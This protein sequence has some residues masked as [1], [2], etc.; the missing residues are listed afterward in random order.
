MTQHLTEKRCSACRKIFPATA[1]YFHR[2]KNKKDGLQN[3]CKMCKSIVDAAY[4]LTPGRKIT[5]KR[6]GASEKGK[7]S[8][9]RY[10]QSP[11]GKLAKRK[12]KYKCR[13]GLVIKEFNQ[14]FNAQKGCCFIC[15]IHQSEV[16]QRLC[17][18]HDH[19]TGE[20]RK[21]LCSNC[22]RGLGYFKDDPK[23]LRIAAEYLQSRFDK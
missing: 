13:Y 4:R 3:Q 16:K 11:K 22:N 12:V 7:E 21:L 18:D 9:K 20:I 14:M 5:L 19:R 6:Y 23:I 8:A 1:D 2:N 10:G 17:I 15:G